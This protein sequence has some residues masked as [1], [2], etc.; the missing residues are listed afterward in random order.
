VNGLALLEARPAPTPDK[1]ILAREAF[2]KR[3]LCPRGEQGLNRN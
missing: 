2:W 3:I 1:M